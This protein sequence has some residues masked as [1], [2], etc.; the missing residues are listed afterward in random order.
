MKIFN[1]IFKDVF[2]VGKIFNSLTSYFYNLLT[3]DFYELDNIDLDEEYREIDEKE[4]KIFFK[5]GAKNVREFYAISF[6][7]ENSFIGIDLL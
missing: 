7:K 4:K 3:S 5:Y 2:V 6:L 1:F